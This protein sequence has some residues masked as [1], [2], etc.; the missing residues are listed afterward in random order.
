[1]TT[2]MTEAA[3]WRMLAEW[4]GEG[5]VSRRRYL[6]LRLEDALYGWSDRDYDPLPK[7][8]PYERMERRLERHSAMSAQGRYARLNSSRN[9]ARV[10]FCLLMALECD[11]EA[12]NG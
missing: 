11:E 2:K 1:M 4:C 8:I 10:I 12:R 7:G 6:C 3:A 5:K 9:H